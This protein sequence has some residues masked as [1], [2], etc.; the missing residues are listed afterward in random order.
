M[1]SLQ[2]HVRAPAGQAR[3]KKG[4][5]DAAASGG[6]HKASATK[7]RKVAARKAVGTRRRELSAQVSDRVVD[8]IEIETFS[9]EVLTT[10]ITGGRGVAVDPYGNLFQ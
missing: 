5:N 1:V 8:P 10:T 3:C 4:C 9:A 7:K 6:G 2:D